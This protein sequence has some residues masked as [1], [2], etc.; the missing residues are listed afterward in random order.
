[1]SAPEPY[2]VPELA[3]ADPDDLYIGSQVWASLT[4]DPSVP[5]VGGVVVDAEAAGDHWWVKTIEVRQLSAQARN[6]V[7]PHT[8]AIAD[9]TQI[10]PP[11]E[12]T[13]YKEVRKLLGCVCAH[14]GTAAR[15]P[16]SDV[17][18]QLIDY[19]LRLLRGA[20]T[21]RWERVG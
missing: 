1:M 15:R 3:L 16:V 2:P 5:A 17:E 21:G 7:V 6:E 12:A 8:L 20:V 18:R 11:L 13:V 9:L 4:S 14:T 10:N 19:A